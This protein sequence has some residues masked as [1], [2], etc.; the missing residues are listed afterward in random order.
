VEV[1]QP[2]GPHCCCGSPNDR[3]RLPKTK[4]HPT[5]KL[6]AT[7]PNFQ[8]GCWAYLDVGFV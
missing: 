6:F 3:A 2:K 8:A 7:W 4:K 1:A 5:Y